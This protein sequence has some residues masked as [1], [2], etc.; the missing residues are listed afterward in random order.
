MF[1][2]LE[3]INFS[4]AKAFLYGMRTAVNNVYMSQ[5][6]PPLTVIDTYFEKY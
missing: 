3:I 4:Q 2:S 1:S 6:D 5:H